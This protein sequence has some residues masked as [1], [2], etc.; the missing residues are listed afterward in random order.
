MLFIIGAIVVVSCVLGGFMWHGGQPMALNQPNELLIIGGAAL[1]SLIISTPISVIKGLIAQIM[2]VFSGKRYSKQDY[3]DLLVMLYEIFNVARRD[4]LVGLE[5]HI[6]H[7]E[8]SE[9]I[10]RYPKFLKNHHAVAFFSDTMR[11]IISGSVQPHDLEDLMNADLESGHND[12]MRPANA[13]A[14]IADALPG[15]GIVAAV[16]GV[17]LTMSKINA[18]PEVI[19][20]SVAAALVGTFLGVLA[21]YGFVGPLANSLKNAIDENAQYLNCMKHA[22]LSFHKGVAGVISVEFARRTLFAEVRPEFLELE[23]ACNEAKRR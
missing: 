3:Q 16:M 2:A 13:L 15:L 23:K 19:G 14:M 9:I 7:P 8:E 11:I 17:V 20:E 10:N 1:G 21:C 22:L 5:S 6:E 18:G 4:G 12:E